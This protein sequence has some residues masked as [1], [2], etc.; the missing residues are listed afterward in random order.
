M[1]LNNVP[2]ELG[3]HTVFPLVGLDS[4]AL[5]T[6]VPELTVLVQEGKHMNDTSLAA[7]EGSEVYHLAHAMC[8][9]CRKGSK[10]PGCISPRKETKLQTSVCFVR[11]LV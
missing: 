5:A 8:E 4:S 1:Y 3:G 11:S 6:A 2:A 9:R 7:D 10:E